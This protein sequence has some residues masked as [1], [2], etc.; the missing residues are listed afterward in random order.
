VG[1]TQQADPVRNP[2]YSVNDLVGVAGLEAGLEEVLFGAAGTPQDEVDNRGN[3]VAS[4]VV[5]HA[6][7][8]QDGGLTLDPQVQRVAEDV[9]ASALEL[10]NEDRARVGLPLEEQVHGALV[11]LDPRTGEILAM[12]SYPPST[13]TC[14]PTAPPTRR[15]WRRSSTTAATCRSR[16]APWRRTRRPRPSSSSPPR[17]CWSTATPAPTPPTPARRRSASAA[18]PGRTGPTTTR[19]TT[20]R[21]TPSPTA[22]T[23]T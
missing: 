22:A 7:P 13:R 10:V 12:A 18:S 20:T 16:T 6:Q 1:Y 5:L 2:G 21:A 8:G 3:E 11:A 4:H 14:S 19:A 23:P 15:R 17:R 9:L